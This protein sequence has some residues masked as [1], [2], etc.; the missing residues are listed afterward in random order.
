MCRI[1]F[2]RV[3]RLRWKTLIPLASFLA[4]GISPSIGAPVSSRDCQERLSEIA[5]GRM[6][7]DDTLVISDCLIAGHTSDGEIQRAYDK[8]KTRT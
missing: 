4:I 2:A 7:G 3:G 8:A 6:S 1:I 5:N